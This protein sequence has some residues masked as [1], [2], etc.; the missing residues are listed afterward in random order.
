MGRKSDNAAL[1][2]Y[3]G[4]LLVRVT[5]LIFTSLPWTVGRTLAGWLADLWRVLKNEERIELTLGNI[6][7][8]F[9]GM[10][11]ARAR[12]ILAS[13]CRRTFR[14]AVDGLQFRALK[15][16]GWQRLVDVRGFDKLPEP[17]A[18]QGI[19]FTSGH[20]GSWELLAVALS[21]L[22][23]PVTTVIRPVSNPF[24]NKYLKRL[25]QSGG[26][27]VVEKGG[28]VRALLRELRQGRNAAFLVDQDARREG[29]FVD[30]LG[31][32]ACTYTSFARLSISTGAPVAFIYAE[33]LLP[34][35]R[36]RIEVSDVVWP[37]TDVDRD[38]E[39]FRITQRI[40]HDLE[41]LV[42]ENPGEW[43]WT[44]RRWKTWPGKFAGENRPK[45][46]VLDRNSE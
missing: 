4:Y 25:R 37:R 21:R 14:T 29:V 13:S 7:K 35:P 34:G 10:S 22:G 24:I 9:P 30:F 33:D 23:Y 6:Q 38:E 28:A 1:I 19:I 3:L 20:Y 16:G 44:Q 41:E 17:G 12:R 46:G 15:D 43:M 18:D 26:Q 11:R 40:T 2:D 5:A 45:P 32:P 8:A 27:R 39:V 36:F 42:R 31:R